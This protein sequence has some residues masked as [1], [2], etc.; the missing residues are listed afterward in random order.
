MK[1]EMKQIPK[2]EERRQ[3]IDELIRK[4]PKEIESAVL[5]TVNDIYSHA[6]FKMRRRANLMNE[7]PGTHE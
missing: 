2:A 5:P 7:S 4:S 3:K 1:I 6:D